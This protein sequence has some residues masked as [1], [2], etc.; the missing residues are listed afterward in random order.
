[1]KPK[2]RPIHDQV[3]V[4]VGA[5][6]GIGL[7]TAMTMAEKGARVVIVGRSQEG[8]NEALERVRSHAEASRIERM[9]DTNGGR[10]AAT[11]A[12]SSAFASTE[13][14]G[15][16]VA[17]MEDQV[18]ALE[19]DI[20]DFEQM[21]SVAEQVVQR[22]GRID[23]WVN[24]AAVSE[25]ALFEDTSPDEFRRIIE[26]NLIGQAYGAMA[27]L[28]YLRQ[29]RGGALIF[30]SSVAGR[31]PIP[32]Q[33]AYN[34]SKH[35]LIGLIETLRLELKHTDAP[36]SVTNIVPA[37]MNTPL[38][39][40]ARTKLGVEPDPI[41]PIYD[42]KMVAKAITYAA[43]HPV[44]ELIVGD[45]GYMLTFMRRLAPTMTSNFMGATG[46]RQ[47]RSSEPKSAQAPDNLYEHISGYNKVSGDYGERTMRVAPLTWLSTHPRARAAIYGGLL[48]LLGGLVGWQIVKERA[49]RRR[50][51]RYRLPRQ[52]RM[53]SKQVRV[54]AGKALHNA[55]D[56]I[57]GMPYVSDLP[58]F[59]RQQTMPQKIGGTLSGFWAA[60]LAL[61]PF[62]RR[63]KTLPQRIASRMQDVKMPSV[64]MPEVHLPE[65]H[66]PEI[67]LPKNVH[68]ADI[69]MPWRNKH[70]EGV[71]KVTVVD[72]RGKV[73]RR[74]AK[75]SEKAHNAITSHSKEISR[76]VDK[77]MRQ[78]K[79]RAERSPVVERRESVFERVSFR[80]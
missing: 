70:S 24:V 22:F 62:R 44:R 48:A 51:W 71:K 47:Q 42:A 59:H 5:N 66:R 3:A 7:E 57:A 50:S 78:S 29:Q 49:Q 31:V 54:S 69:N 18:I 43:T 21:R 65:I 56:A 20:T 6:S 33:S 64:H 10:R 45:A 1:M 4:L 68:L 30:V 36:V 77:A 39:D 9:Y 63:Q 61:L 67:H 27:A 32:Y 46:F 53:I 41:P 60:F 11:A 75:A 25:W 12:E 2:L 28:P 52:A 23:T 35:G 19:G 14:G 73:G 58:M 26:V 37:S 55:G 72:E 40:K 8:L 38:F 34:A 13:M 16:P 80:K 15:A 17:T 76:A 74:V 79:D